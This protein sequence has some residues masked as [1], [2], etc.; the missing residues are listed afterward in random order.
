MSIKTET[1]QLREIFDD[2]SEIADAGERRAFVR[3][4]CGEN[5][6]L[7]REVEDLLAAHDTAGGFFDAMTPTERPPLP[8]PDEEKIGNYRLIEKL[9]EGGGGI[10]WLAEQFEPVRRRVA[11]KILKPGMDT[12]SVIARFEAERQALALMDHP[13]IAR[14]FDAGTSPLGRPFFVMELVSGIRITKFCDERRIETAARLEL[15][16]RVCQAV[17][18]AHQ[19]G[20]IHR[21]LKPS[22]ILVSPSPDEGGAPAPKVIDFGI[23]KATTDLRLT[24][25][26]LVTH[27]E[28]LIGTPAYMSPEQAELGAV[29]IDTR[30]DIYSLG[31][32]LY[33]L[34]TGK[35]PFESE[36]LL[37]SGFD[38]MRRTIRETTPTRPSTRLMT[39][40]V[41]GLTEVARRHQ[42]E[43]DR[44]VSLLQGDLDWIVLKAL[45]K[46]RAR[47]YESASG[48][49][50]DVQR[51]LRNEPVEARPPSSLYALRKLVRRHRTAF[52]VAAGVA[53]LLV[54]ASII[55]LRLAWRAWEAEG[56]QRA[57][58]AVAESAR[59][60]AEN[61]AEENRLRLVQSHV[62]RGNQ[63]IGEGDFCSA[64]LPLV[65]ALN[66]E[67]SAGQ[68]TAAA[69]EIQRRRVGATLRQ[70][71]R[72]MEC[73]SFP[74]DSG[75]AHFSPD[76]RKLVALEK[77]TVRV[78]DADTGQ[79]TGAAFTLDQPAS[80]VW[81]PLP[82]RVL[83]AD[84][85]GRLRL[86]DATTGQPATPVMDTRSASDRGAQY[87]ADRWDV[88]P[89]GR[90][91][92]APV[93]GGARLFDLATG[94]PTGPL[95][96]EGLAIYQ[97]G[98]SPDGG[99]AFLSCW[100]GGGLRQIEVPSGSVL[101][102]GPF[103]EKTTA[104]AFA[105][106]LDG[107]RLAIV[108]GKNIAALDL[109]DLVEKKPL[110]SL[111]TDGY[112]VDCAFTPDSR[113]LVVANRARTQVFDVATGKVVGEPVAHRSF[114]TSVAVSPDGKTFASTTFEN[115][116]R[117]HDTTTGQPRS[118]VFHHPGRVEEIQFGLDGR[119]FLT[120]SL[121]GI[122]RLWDVS[123]ADA[124]RLS[125]PH[126]GQVQAMEFSGDGLRILSC[127]R[128]GTACVRE[129]ATGRLLARCTHPAPVVAGH[130]S[131]DGK[132][133]VTGCSDG[134]VRI[135][136]A[137]ESESLIASAQ[138]TAAVRQVSFSPDGQLV[139]SCSDDKTARLWT[140][141]T[142]APAGPALTHRSAVWCA[143]FSPDGRRF[144]TG[145]DREASLWDPATC[146]RIGQPLPHDRIV[147][148]AAFT[149]DGTRLATAQ[150]RSIQLFETATGKRLGP[151]IP[152][153]DVT[154]TLRASPD[155]SR[156]LAA[157]WLGTASL[158]DLGTGMPVAPALQHR[159]KVNAAKFSP[160]GKMILTFSEDGTAQVW[161]TA[162]G[163]P[164]T[165]PLRHGGNVVCGAWSPDESLV[166]TGSSDGTVRLWDLAPISEP[167]ADLRLSAELLSTRK[168]Q[169]GAGAIAL[170][171]AEIEDR[172]R[173]Q[174]KR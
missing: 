164:V 87:D 59:R 86:W 173:K 91:L 131:P 129:V 47:R 162:T 157:S 22:N 7:L 74:D 41:A 170:T 12:R 52:A 104:V 58:R 101:W 71:P 106:S 49:A 147:T 18:H 31:V 63:L 36:T 83:V 99:S 146:K 105:I 141:A 144:A 44:L 13:G 135:W 4:A 98:F 68:P 110:H 136:R 132:T 38:A 20:I 28:M 174:A 130:F 166:A 139:L 148:A 155:G 60:D 153:D 3:K 24:E 93:E 43:P 126:G 124:V 50:A 39:L 30:S 35:T 122:T 156:I 168:L 2:A 137:G 15:F 140:A 151:P 115:V 11:L 88:S 57:L 21:D 95:M 120:R 142:G 81:L 100:G 23:A 34:L 163:Q 85:A 114:V 123:G 5:A 62:A 42:A 118:P 97:L 165:P 29:E 90:W 10:V 107:A 78:L 112:I 82:D 143:V 75:T 65:D 61:H 172:W 73:W 150:L 27:A 46:D 79:P 109:W 116:T 69:V 108:S 96:A 125:L 17:Q 92:L 160:D 8:P 128:D 121:G 102:Q 16:I 171:S 48:L 152:S 19:K 1:L 138:H 127:S 111:V 70:A 56:Q 113:R 54:A 161:E 134:S 117:I 158:F 77:G 9:G 6:A 33:E 72:L 53:I 26:T 14:V 45:E 66:L 145:A 154:S 159:L 67:E 89:D 76:G 103:A 119:R 169:A 94:L 25:K 37:K 167:V 40:D 55:S 64:L 51:Y 149:P 80:K 32:L 84:A 133:I